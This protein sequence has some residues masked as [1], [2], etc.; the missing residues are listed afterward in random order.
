M[1]FRRL[2]PSFL[3]GYFLVV[4][5][6]AG[7]FNYANC[8]QHITNFESKGLPQSALQAV[9][10]LMKV[11]RAEKESPQLLKGW[12]YRIHFLMEKDQDAFSS[13]LG[14][15]ETY[16]RTTDDPA[17][18]A[19]VCGTSPTC[20]FAARQ[21]LRGELVCL[22]LCQYAG[23]GHCSCQS[24]NSRQ[25]PAMA[26]IGQCAE[27][28]SGEERRGEKSPF[29]RN[30]MKILIVC[31]ATNQQVAPFIK[32]QADSLLAC[33]QTVEF[34]LIRKKGVKGYLDALPGL[35][36][37]IAAFRP[38]VIHD[39]RDLWKKYDYRRWGIIGEPYFDIDFNELTYLTD[40]GRCWNGQK[41]NIRDKVEGSDFTQ[42]HTTGDI[43]GAVSRGMLPDKIM[44][45]THPQRWTDNRWKWWRELISQNLKNE[46]KRII[47][48]YNRKH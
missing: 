16:T 44:F 38:D 3:L 42:F 17:E 27:I 9:D 1:N 37:T 7:S 19:M 8:W 2:F 20:P 46:V 26:A 43:I 22:L 14:A 18:K 47:V 30:S 10:S 34:Y 15:M 45:T 13:E 41:Y 24:E 28:E 21:R 23:I 4:S 12:L 40:T 36:S 31:S 6:A 35:K 29:D 25:L 32:E 5:A 48:W 33:G 11:A 39:N